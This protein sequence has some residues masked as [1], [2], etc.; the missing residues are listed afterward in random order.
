MLSW[1]KLNEV[2]SDLD[3][4]EVVKLLENE[5]I[6]ARRAMVMIRL[7]QRFCTLRMARERNQLF[8]E[9]Q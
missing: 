6:G 2:L 4:E 1:R 7:H 3:E 5:K 9:G 8:G